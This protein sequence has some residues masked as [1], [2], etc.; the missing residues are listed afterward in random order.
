MHSAPSAVNRETQQRTQRAASGWAAA[1]SRLRRLKSQKKRPDE[2][3]QPPCFEM[4]ALILSAIASS[5]AAGV[6][7]PNARQLDFMSLECAA[8]FRPLRLLCL[9]L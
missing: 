6:P 5:A 4:A 2:T 9:L 7:V 1:R 8:F 3:A